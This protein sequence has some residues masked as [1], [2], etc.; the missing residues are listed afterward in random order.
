MTYPSQTKEAYRLA[1][2]KQRQRQ[3]EWMALVNAKL[4]PQGLTH[5]SLLRGIVDGTIEVVKIKENES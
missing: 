3:A 2:Q 5:E 1:K 4:A